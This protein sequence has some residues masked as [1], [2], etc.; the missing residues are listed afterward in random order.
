MI[1]KKTETGM[2]TE[3]VK[4]EDPPQKLMNIANS[5]LEELEEEIIGT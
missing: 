2:I 4:R 5:S 3:K 1:V